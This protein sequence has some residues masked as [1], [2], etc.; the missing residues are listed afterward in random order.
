MRVKAA[1]LVSHGAPLRIEEVDL[2]EPREDEV[3]VDMAFGGVN[4]VD[5]YAA[6]G[7]SAPDAPVPRT[8]GTEGSGRVGDRAVLIHGSGVGT[9]T[10]G[11]WG[12][13]AVVPKKAVIDVPD[14][15]ELRDA[16]ALGI[17]GATA[18]NVVKESARVSSDDRVLVLGA[19]G[20]VGSMIVSL[21]HWLGANV[22][23]QTGDEDNR[24]WLTGLGAD[25][26]VVSGEDGSIAGAA[27]L[28]PSVVFD[29]LG[30][31]FTAQAINLMHTHG[32]LVL[33]GTSAATTGEVPLQAVYRKGLTLYGYAGLIAPEAVLI[34]AKRQALLAVAEGKMKVTIGATYPL[35][36]VN[37]AF[38]RL[39]RRNVQGKV[40][41]D[42]QR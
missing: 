15:V 28:E 4:P 36:G 21:C 25:S 14:R 31:G 7:L 12:T 18:W 2:P 41:L 16:A 3:F 34:E 11:L 26:V 20:G 42:L 27:D 22:C 17:A 35:N 6:T 10:D 9:A 1:R 32:R 38:E 30:N 13:G 33:F 37:E 24:S 23:A 29:P 5:R 40:L 19:S 8:M 39:V